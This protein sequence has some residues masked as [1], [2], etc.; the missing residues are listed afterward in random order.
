MNQF[1]TA[2]PTLAVGLGGDTRSGL[3][4]LEDVGGHRF[5]EVE[6][7]ILHGHKQQV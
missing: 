7:L 5:E 4:F 1:Y 6:H 3:E 2:A